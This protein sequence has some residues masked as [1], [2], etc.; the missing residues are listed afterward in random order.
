MRLFHYRRGILTVT[1]ALLAAGLAACSGG[2]SRP[3]ISSQ[4]AASG[5]QAQ[6]SLGLPPDS[7]GPVHWQMQSGGAAHDGSLQALA[8]LPG[9]ITVDEGDSITWTSQ[10]EPH[11]VT[12]LGPYSSPPANP[13]APQGGTSFDG[14]TFV[15]SGFM[16][17]GQQF[18]LTFTKAGTYAYFCVLHAP[19]MSGVVVVQPRG[20]P[21]PASQTAYD[22]TGHLQE[23]TLLGEAQAA[24][25]RLPIDSGTTIAAG[26]SGP[27]QSDGEP[28]KATVL[29]FLDR[30]RLNSTTITVRAGTTITWRNL[31]NNE[32]HTVTFPVAGQPL[33]PAYGNPFSPPTGGTTYDGSEIVNSGVLNSGDEFHLTFTK[34]GTYAYECLFH[35]EE[36]MEGTVIVK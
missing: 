27:A 30:D 10:G 17:P 3:P 12:F 18:T 22:V 32:P 35:D 33:P 28:S 23:L 34:P 21:Y 36:H 14:S 31:S 29:S 20:T 13:T 16:Q 5:G 7:A 24:V 19:E 26:T 25:L 4:P 6:Q 9:K 15:S 1:A 11:T 8:F 2:G